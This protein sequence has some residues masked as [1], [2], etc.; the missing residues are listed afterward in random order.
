MIIISSEKCLGYFEYGQPESPSRIS[1]TI[2]ILKTAGY[3]FQEPTVKVSETELAEAHS[4]TYVE[5]IKNAT[6]P[7][8]PECPKYPNLFFCASLAVEAALTTL[9]KTLQGENSFSLMRPPG[10]HAGKRPMG[11][12]YFNNAA[13]VTLGALKHLERAAV[14]DID[15]HHGNGTQEILFAKE[16]VLHADIHCKRSWPGTGKRSER[17]CLNFLVEN[18]CSEEEYLDKL[19]HALVE[20]KKF[21]PKILIVSAGFDTFKNDPVGG[22]GLEI[23]TYKKIGER[24]NGS[25]KELGIKTCSLLE[26]GYSKELPECILEYL[27]A[28][29]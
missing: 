10:H 7:Y 8:D 2:P 18:F 3:I 5:S 27:R 9:E 20:I 26:G 23:R 6:F 13:I 15:Y 16:N 22:L 28:F 1:R 19:E 4:P 11:F 17:N 12:C 29:E 24:I 14:L 21:N 25:A